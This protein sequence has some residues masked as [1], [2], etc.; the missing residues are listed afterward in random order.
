[1]DQRQPL[2][3]NAVEERRPTDMV[4]RMV[5]RMDTGMETH[6]DTVKGMGGAVEVAVTVA[7]HLRLMASEPDALKSLIPTISVGGEVVTT[8][9][10][11]V[12]VAVAVAVAV[13]AIPGR[14]R[15]KGTGAAGASVCDT[16]K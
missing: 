9:T 6:S 16:N 11:V 3:Q 13:V 7:F 14:G 2:P 1:M 12:A 4:M 5:M 10:V 15:W 8:V